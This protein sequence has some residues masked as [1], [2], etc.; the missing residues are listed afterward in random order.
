MRLIKKLTIS[1][2]FAFIFSICIFFNN[3]FGNP[4]S[5]SEAT[6]LTETSAI[7]GL[8][9]LNLATDKKYS[10]VVNIEA[11]TSFSITNENTIKY[12][13]ILWDSLP[14]TL[15]I[16]DNISRETLYN[17]DKSHNEFLHQLIT[18]PHNM[19]T[20]NLTLSLNGDS[21]KMAELY[22]FGEGSLPNF[23][24]DWNRPYNKA[25]LLLLSTHADDEHIFYGGTMPFYSGEENLKVQVAYL[26][27]HYNYRV[28]ELLNGLWEV[29]IR[30][31]PIISNF[32]DYY[33]ESLEQAKTIYDENAILEYQVMLL[34]RF[35]PSVVIGHDLN[36][37]YGHGVHMLNANCLTKSL[38]LSK[39]E[40]A[41]EESYE[42]YG[43]WEV[44]KCYLHLYKENSLNLNWS[45]PLSAFNGKTAL[46][47]AKEGFSKHYSQTE[48]FSV[49]G[50]GVF[51]CTAFGLY[52]S[53]V[54][55]DLLKNDFLE[56]INC[57]NYNT[58]N[59]ESYSLD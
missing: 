5:S 16:I 11:N 34:R 4:N 24:Q 46:D 1:I 51:D 17:C 20:N 37:E 30:A 59:L 58:N 48:Y 38:E 23:V 28:H 53:T 47:M 10:T 27:N 15:T 9:G 55:E 19:P 29:G 2:A 43:L 18:L 49:G 7:D 36:G 35:K 54:G 8:Y 41:Y 40:T 21:I 52:N 50:K 22:V 39:D 42:K 25:D 3:S 13:Y 14:E 45:K 26:T 33:A 31:Y 44:H 32:P 56:N 57:R 6:D 12:I